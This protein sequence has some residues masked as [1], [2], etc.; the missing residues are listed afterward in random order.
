MNKFTPILVVEDD[1]H[2]VELIITALQH[3]RIFNEVV[4][5]NDGAAALDF[6]FG[7]AQY[8][9]R[10]AGNPILVL[11]DLNIPKIEGLEVLRQIKAHEQ[12]KTIP[13]VILTGSHQEAAIVKSYELGVNAYVIKPTLFNDFSAVVRELGLFWAIINEP[14]N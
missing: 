8:A 9:E 4:A 10:P 3:N 1:P 11:L 13:V 7:R 5:V 14:P 6:L 2:D 12:L